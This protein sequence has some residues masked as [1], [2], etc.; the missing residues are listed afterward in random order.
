MPIKTRSGLGLALSSR[1]RSMKNPFRSL[2]RASRRVRKG[3]AVART[4]QQIFLPFV[5]PA[6]RAKKPRKPS[7][8]RV[9]SKS[10]QGKPVLPAFIDGSFSGPGGKLEYKLYSPAGFSRQK[11]PLAVMLHGCK[12]WAADF[13]AGTRMN[14]L[15]DEVG[16]LVLYPQQSVSA[17]LAR[18]WN[19]YRPGNQR[20]GSG[21]PAAIAALTQHVMRICKADPSRV[22]IAGISAGGSAAAIIGSAYPELYAAVGVHSGIARG[23][24]TT[25]RG[26]MS[27]MQSGANAR[28]RPG[29]TTGAPRPTIVFH[30]D[31][32]TVVH[33][34]NAKGFLTDLDQS[35]PDSILSFPQEGTSGGRDFIRTEYRHG[36]GAVMLECWD[37]HGSGPRLVRR[38]LC[39]IVFGPCRS[40]RIA[41]DGALFSGTKTVSSSA[42]TGRDEAELNNGRRLRPVVPS[43]GE[44]PM[45]DGDGGLEPLANIH[46]ELSIRS[47]HKQSRDGNLSTFLRLQPPFSSRQAAP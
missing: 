39:R 8:R 10:L 18:C 13:A 6:K 31:R 3:L 33:P 47:V 38:K 28:T 4:V 20:R 37:V 42:R 43:A 32:D 5:T 9:A 40:R 35:S 17:N 44:R 26:A 25:L 23:N 12:Q 16:L 30:G 7:V 41:R 11:L 15:A 1:G 22:C 24:V 34:S 2:M 45:A 14:K 27:A 46:V 29:K 21:E 19:W 36:A